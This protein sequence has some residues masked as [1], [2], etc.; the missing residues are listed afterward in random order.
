M[1]T[2]ISKRERVA[3]HF[4][5]IL[6]LVVMASFALDSTVS[7]VFADVSADF[8]QA[9]AYDDDGQYAQAA[10]IFQ[11]IIAQYYGTE[12]ALI[13][14]TEL[15]RMYVFAGQLQE[16]QAAYQ[17]LVNSFYWYEGIA[18]AVC[19]VADSYLYLNRQ[20]QKALEIYQ[21]VLA[22]WPS[23]SD[24]MWAQ[25][26]VVK[27]RILL[28][29]ES[30]AQSAYQ[31]LL[32]QYAKHRNICEA[33]Y[34]VGD[35]YRLKNPQKALEHYNYALNTWPDYDAWIDENDA[36]SR[37]KNLVLLKLGLE[38]EVGAQV[39]YET[40]LTKFSE[41]DNLSESVLEVANTYLIS[42]RTQK[43]VELYQY[44]KT[45]W[46]NSEEQIW[47][48]AGLVKANVAVGIDPNGTGVDELFTD[49]SEDSDLAKAVYTVME[50]YHYVALTKKNQGNSKQAG[51]YFE[52]VI[53]LG[54]NLIKGPLDP[55]DAD[56]SSEVRYLMGQ[57]FQELGDYEKAIEYYEQV[58][59]GWPKGAHAWGAQ[60]R[61]G[62]TYE[63]LKKRGLFSKS[64]VDDKIESAY[65]KV[66]Q[67]YPDCPAAKA[68][69]AWLKYHG[70]SN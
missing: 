42:G 1:F 30:S 35:T 47:F 8:N 59:A 33:V 61:I 29:D 68:A 24:T 60:F 50:Q 16:A 44:A 15:T 14:Q 45:Q 65:Q 40:L 23:Q 19:E 49:F 34:E 55:S 43:A 67:N 28:G 22:N 66:L 57:S 48:E 9:E 4:V 54:R 10:K 12:N 69:E 13:S 18:K 17:E 56:L 37:R 6:F 58:V 11:N 25:A 53:S 38:D 21:Y 39:A 5:M 46:S 3:S 27:A 26:G 36:L 64:G 41:I 52:K 63:Q 2:E 51:E 31:T 7:R 62:Y 70:K 32:T 20:P